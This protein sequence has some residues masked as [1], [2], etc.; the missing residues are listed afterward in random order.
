MAPP[1]TVPLLQVPLKLT[2]EVVWEGPLGDHIRDAYADDPANY[3]QP[4]A[5][6]HKLR[7]DMRGAPSTADKT[8]RDLLLKYYGQIE[9]LELHFPLDNDNLV[10]TWYDAFT[11]APTAQSSLAYE[12]ASVI[13]NLAAAL[14]RWAAAPAAGQQRDTKQ[15]YHSLQVAA[16][17]FQFINDNFLHAPTRDLGR[18]CIRVLS[19]LMVAQAQELLVEKTLADLKPGANPTKTT[20]KMVAGLAH[21]YA[22]LAATVNAGDLANYF[23]VPHR[24]LPAIIA[25]KAKLYSAQA[26][27]MRAKHLEADFNYAEIIPRLELA[28][29][30]A[31]EAVTLAKPLV[32]VVSAATTVTTPDAGTVLLDLAKSLVATCTEA[33]TR[34]TKDND[35]IYHAATLAKDALPPLDHFVVPQRLGFDH[36]LPGGA[37]ELQGLVTDLFSALIPLAV[38]EKASVY[39][40]QKAQVQRR[41]SELVEVLDTEAGSLLGA[42][43][44]PKA[45]ETL[46]SAVGSAAPVSPVAEVQ[47]RE[48]KSSEIPDLYATVSAMASDALAQIQG[49][50]AKLDQRDA[51]D[52]RA[53]AALPPST[54]WTISDLRALPA[55]AA[56]AAAQT[57]LQQ[58]Q[59]RDALVLA[60][61]Q[62][63]NVPSSPDA[64]AG[65]SGR[66]ASLLDTGNDLPALVAKARDLVSLL[67]KLK[68]DR[69]KGLADLKS[70]LQKDDIADV[71]VLNAKQNIDEHIFRA[72]LAKFQGMQDRLAENAKVTRA[73]LPALQATWQA[74]VQHPDARAAQSRDARA[75]QWERTVA[76]AHKQVVQWQNK[77]QDAAAE[78]ADV[79]DAVARHVRDL[80]RA[81]AEREREV[82]EVQKKA[83]GDAASRQ[84]DLLRD[85]LA[86]MSL[87]GST[88]SGSAPSSPYAAASKPAFPTPGTYQA[89]PVA[90]GSAY[91]PATPTAPSAPSPGGYFSGST[92]AAYAA[93]STA[94]N[95]AG[96]YAAASTPPSQQ[97]QQPSSFA[98]TRSLYQPPTAAA[99]AHQSYATPPPP[100]AYGT[101]QQQ[102]PPAQT[103]PSYSSP[104]PADYQRPASYAPP[105][106]QQ[107][108]QQHAPYQQPQATGQYGYPSA[109]AP[110]NT[111]YYGSQPP[112]QGH[113]SSATPAYAGY[114]AAAPTQQPPAAQYQ[115]HQQLPTG[116]YQGYGYPSAAY[117]QQQQQPAS[118]YN[119]PAVGYGGYPQAQQQQYQQT[120]YQ[121]PQYQQQRQQPQQQQQQYGSQYPPPSG[122]R[123]SLMD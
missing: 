37:A 5:A 48:I 50:M 44:L 115:Q 77:L 6:L 110:S 23:D 18:D 118:Q 20:A 25:V 86:R 12:K 39:S 84:R 52:V 80:E 58:T 79:Q 120:Q 68:A 2:D 82:V 96:S 10:F 22:Q 57:K 35:V 54:E 123:P 43:G 61:Y 32:H 3:A 113:Y 64:A 99:P 14:S 90:T 70:A 101:Q 26:H 34:A 94:T 117:G 116:Q 63:L 30:D 40:E 13:F 112:Q 42:L 11:S 8:A 122:G 45:L 119:A 65:G 89:P 19:D 85:Q 4:I 60:D 91:Q 31:K 83:V 81:I 56:L 59:A 87:G 106:A 24:V 21:Q 51:D 71:L 67:S 29:A 41:A 107:Q 98:A 7:Q 78:L 27:A 49:V 105:P 17:I 103:P 76:S 55:V 92:P 100:S 97:Q 108:Q 104:A 62:A 102:Q 15:A 111:N 114:A 28:V 93:P 53:R 88:G 72:E 66:D 16:G 1:T 121:A 73:T 46:T 74:I 9:L 69:T 47:V 75:A 109:A 95:Y 33:L 38:H 36:I